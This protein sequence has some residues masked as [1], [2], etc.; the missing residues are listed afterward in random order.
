MNPIEKQVEIIN[1]LAAVM[2]QSADADCETLV[3]RF[4]VEAEDEAVDQAF[5]FVKNG[6]TVSA[7]LDD[8]DWVVTDWVL[9][10]YKEMKSHTGGNWTAFTLTIG[11]DGKASTR[12]EYPED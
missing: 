12:F 10:L 9:D 1:N 11:G 3:C 7:F 6:K 2:Q 8:P 4:E 5:S